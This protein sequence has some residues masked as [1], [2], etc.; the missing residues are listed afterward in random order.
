MS[1][2]YPSDWD[3]R[4]KNVYQR[5][6]YTCQ[7]C[8]AMGGPQGHAEL[9]AHHIVPKSRGG[10][11]A[12]SNLISLCSECH[13]T[14]HSKSKQAPSPQ[15]SVS[16]QGQEW[17]DL[18]DAIIQDCST[19]IQTGLDEITAIFADPSKE[20][21]Q[22]AVELQ[23][24]SVEYRQFMLDI[25]DAISTLDSL[26]NNNYPREVIKT[27][28][29]AIDVGEEIITKMLDLIEEMEEDM[30]KISE[31]LTTCP[32]CDADVHEEDEFCGECGTEIEIQ[33]KCQNC[34]SAIS[35]SD[36]FCRS[37]GESVEEVQ[38]KEAID[39]GAKA[40]KAEQKLEDFLLEIE[41]I[42][43]RFADTVERRAEAIDKH[44]RF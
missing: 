22:Q 27:N 18:S 38:E 9:H 40:D 37:C 35:H 36:D 4:R 25:T 28:Q 31:M 2:G 30:A 23:Q 26:S 43:D 42:S 17:G 8:G 14:V 39:P 6:D 12:T 19:L 24:L 5:D 33:P 21:N 15:Q 20:V 32:D 44:S 7:N 34:S 41:D 16:N 29:R 10:T 13:N 3:S 11:H 1:T